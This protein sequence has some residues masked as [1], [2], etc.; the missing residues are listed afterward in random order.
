MKIDITE[1]NLDRLTI[2]EGRAQLVVWDTKLPGFGAVVGRLSQSFV[3]N[4]RVNG[5][6]KRETVARRG[7]ARED[8]TT[9]TATLARQRALELLGQ[10]AGGIDIQAK[11]EE[12]KQEAKHASGPTLRKALEFHI[13][14]MERGE[15]RRGKVCSPRSVAT[16]RGGIELHL[17]DYLD[18]PIVMLTADVLDGVRQKIERATPRRADADPRN[19]PGRGGANPVLAN[20]YAILG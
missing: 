4:Y 5:A 11:R 18:K 14:K 13:G 12:A 7:A 8:G 6:W 17:A 1:R 20:V 9:W 15:N 19:P 2:P 10:V 3:V 16:L